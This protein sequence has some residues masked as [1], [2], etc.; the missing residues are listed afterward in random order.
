MVTPWYSP[1]TRF[2]VYVSLLFSLSLLLVACGSFP[3]PAQT[4]TPT[5]GRTVT[6]TTVPMPPTQT[7]CPVAETARRAITAPLEL[8]SHANVVYVYNQ[9]PG[10]TPHPLAGILRRYDLTTGSKTDIL[11]VQQASIES[12]QISSDGQ[13]VLFTTL[14]S[15]RSALQLVRMD[16]QGLQ[17]LYCSAPGEQIGAVAWSPEQHFVAFQEGRKVYLLQV[18]T[19][20]LHLAVTS[21]S[22]V[23]Y[24][25]RTWL[26]NTH[27]YLS[28]YGATEMPP[29]NLS[30]LDSS[31]NT[32]Q[33]VL[34]SPILCG[35]FDRSFDSTQLFTS[36]CQFAMPLKIGPSSILVQPATG[37]PAKAIY[38]TPS[39]AITA[40][41]V[42]SSTTLLFVIDNTGVGRI[43]TSHN[44]LWK[45][46]TDGTGLIR[47]TSNAADETTLFTYTR[48]LRSTISS[49]GGNFAA[50]V[51]NTT[52]RFSSLIIGSMNGGKHVA[53]A[54]LPGNTG[55]LDTLDIVGWTTME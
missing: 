9:G 54:S 7:S 49:D 11:H 8:G 39:Y 47:L 10:S 35:D 16:G 31:T 20:T 53:F 24:V 26:D 28:S 1:Y 25:L 51:T 42:A 33:K 50:Q 22:Q 18:A 48:S 32:V 2:F 29:L 38:R 34:T 43:D 19:G 12:A 21:G 14:I 23:G 4:G 6:P 40:L 3:T 52:S 41:R 36:E 17:T 5:T 45:V 15:D 44:G 30:L 27:L 13:W 46:N 37:G 55:T